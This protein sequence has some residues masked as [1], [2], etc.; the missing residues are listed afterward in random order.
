MPSTAWQTEDGFV[1]ALTYG[2]ETAWVKNVQASSTAK[3][4]CD[5]EVIELRDPEIVP[6]YAA[7]GYFSSLQRFVLRPPYPRPAGR[8]YFPPAELGDY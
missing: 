1:I 6:R 4:E 3:L 5:G 2:P 8:R 7:I